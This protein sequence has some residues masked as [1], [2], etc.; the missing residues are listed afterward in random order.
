MKENANA[1]VSDMCTDTP[2][3]VK[4]H[5]RLGITLD[6]LTKHVSVLQEEASTLHGSRRKLREQVTEMLKYEPKLKFIAELEDAKLNILES[7]YEVN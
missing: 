4:G 5:K 2:E 7:K 1:R 3:K 6:R